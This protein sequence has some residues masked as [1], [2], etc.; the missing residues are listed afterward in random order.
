VATC[1]LV[2]GRRLKRLLPAIA[3]SL[4]VG[5]CGAQAHSA[6][7]SATQ[8]AGALKGSPPPLAALHTQADRLLGGG[9][10]AFEARLV[11][12]RG[13]PIVV[14][15]WASWCGP[16]Q[17]EFPAFQRAVLTFGRSIA[18][19]GL[20]GKD[21]DGQA[22]AFLRRFPVTYP[23]YVDPNEDIARKLYAAIY[24][25][26]TI[27]FDRRGSQVYT[28]VGPYES[29]SALERDIRRYALGGA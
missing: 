17:S 14:N 10:T 5:A 11:T 28:H 4:T 12:L 7:P 19:I 6:A 18:F 23:S 24:F 29:T 3:V 9:T 1:R 2:T 22:A 15:K 27:Y 13:Y 25:P 8:I 21:H 26:Q 20:D 16:C